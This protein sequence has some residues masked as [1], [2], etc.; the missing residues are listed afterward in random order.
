MTTK[1]IAISL[2]KPILLRAQA[3]VKNGAAANLSRLIA[4]SL[5]ETTARESFAEMIADFRR[6]SNVSDADVATG[7]ARARAAFDRWDNE[8]RHAK[9]VPRKAR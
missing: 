1:K 2:P 8:K 7:R 3:A 5:D 4:Q 9:A 6:D